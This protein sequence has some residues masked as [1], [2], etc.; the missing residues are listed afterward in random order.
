MEKWEQFTL[1]NTY[2][3]QR[4]VF[5]SCPCDMG[6]FKDA[7]LL[8]NA[9]N[10]VS[11]R[12]TALGFS[13]TRLCGLTDERLFEM[14]GRITF[15]QVSEWVFRLSG[16]RVIYGFVYYLYKRLAL[17]VVGFHYQQGNFKLWNILK[18]A[19]MQTDITAETDTGRDTVLWNC[20]LSWVDFPPASLFLGA[21]RS[22]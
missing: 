14:P 18:Y 9:D 8:D 5:S 10:T 19:N 7:V 21:H 22:C 15:P 13:S 2:M 20:L 17:M 11:I 12:V 1:Y 16:L 4:K 3:K 6:R